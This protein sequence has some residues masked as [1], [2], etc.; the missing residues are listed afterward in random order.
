[1]SL[2]VMLFHFYD[3]SCCVMMCR[4]G[5]R[6]VTQLLTVPE[7]R[8]LYGAW[9]TEK[10]PIPAEPVAVTGPAIKSGASHGGSQPAIRSGHSGKGA[11]IGVPRTQSGLHGTGAG[12]TSHILSFL[13]RQQDLS[14]C[15]H[16]PGPMLVF[17]S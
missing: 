16:S 3:A 8:T 6:C 11:A 15:S 13:S 7:L 14:S 17:S 4:A 12:A 2:F 1:M 10:F 9:F 5:S